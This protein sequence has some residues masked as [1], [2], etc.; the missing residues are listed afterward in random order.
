[1][2]HLHKMELN[3]RDSIT[4]IERSILAFEDDVDGASEPASHEFSFRIAK[5]QSAGPFRDIWASLALASMNARCDKGSVVAWGQH[6]WLQLTSDDPSVVNESSIPFTPAG[7]FAVGADLPIVTDDELRLPLDASRVTDWLTRKHFLLGN[8]G[9]RERVIVEA[10]PDHPIAPTF[11]SDYYDFESFKFALKWIR[12]EL[13]VGASM[14]RQAIG[15]EGWAERLARFLFEIRQNGFEHASKANSIRLLKVKKW[16][17]TNRIEAAKW[18]SAFPQL[19]SYIERSYPEAGGA[20]FYE[21]SISDFG[22]GIVDGFLASPKGAA[23]GT[24]QREEV[25][26]L[27]LHSQLSSKSNDPNA[28]KGIEDALWAAQGMGAFVSLRTGE[29]WKFQDSSAGEL[30]GLRDCRPTE[31]LATVTGTHWQIIYPGFPTDRRT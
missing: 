1:M 16:A 17:F 5:E 27:L 8:G 24:H 6:D 4:A 22:A 7:L 31:K 25:V 19:E 10:D 28:G 11:K 18:A 12:Q 29:F 2:P 26:D 3:R 15:V 9:G 13:E 14:R 21:A 20:F 23:Y 30:F